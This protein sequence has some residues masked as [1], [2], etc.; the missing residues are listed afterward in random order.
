MNHILAGWGSGRSVF[1]LL[2]VVV[3]FA[4][5]AEY[6]L[7]QFVQNIAGVECRV[8]AKVNNR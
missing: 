4:S 5:I 3:V 8:A 7:T 1:L 2:W 6:I